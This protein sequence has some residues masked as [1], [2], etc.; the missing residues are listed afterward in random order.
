MQLVKTKG[1]C[2]VEG[3]LID[4]QANGDS[5]SVDLRQERNADW[6][7]P[8]D[9]LG[10]LKWDGERPVRIQINGWSAEQKIKAK[11]NV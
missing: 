1:V 4:C 8:E 7:R 5:K 11:M 2:V 3:S 6:Q 10:L 9:W